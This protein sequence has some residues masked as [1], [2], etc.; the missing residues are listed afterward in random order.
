MREIFSTTERLKILEAVIFKQGQ[1]SVNETA[2]RLALSK[3]LV[4][5]YL[6]LLAK[7]GMA[8]QHNGKFTIIEDSPLVKGIKVLLNLQRIPASFFKR[9]P[10]VKA[11]GVYGSCAKGE[12]TEE[13][14]LD[15]WILINKAEEA[16][17]A[18]LTSEL[19]KKIE[20][21]KPLLLSKAK[22][23]QLKKEDPLFFYALAFGSIAIYGGPDAFQL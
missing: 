15:V 18:A 13:S 10:F 19:N 2:S 21:V 20:N 11:V 4:S 16:A 5:K 8:R 1:V 22:L 12:N 9:Y 14:D 3:G 23:E 6:D 7:A 17:Q